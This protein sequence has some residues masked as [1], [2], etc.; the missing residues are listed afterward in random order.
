MTNLFDDFEE[1]V[2][3]PRLVPAIDKNDIG[4]S[5]CG[6]SLEYQPAE[7]GDTQFQGVAKFVPEFD[8]MHNSFVEESYQF[9]ISSFLISPENFKLI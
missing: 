2:E 9:E 4:D 6:Y 7:Y 5:K 3:S 8:S 1:S